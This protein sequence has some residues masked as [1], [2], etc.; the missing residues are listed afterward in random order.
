[1]QTQIFPSLYPILLGLVLLTISCKSKKQ[2]VNNNQ[3]KPQTAEFLQQQLAQQQVKADWL[4]GKMKVSFDNNGQQQK[5]FSTLKMRKDS[6]IWMN[7]KKLGIEGARVQITPDSVYLIDRINGQYS[8][9]G[10]D[11]ITKKFNLPANFSM[12]QN[13]LLGNPVFFTR[14]LT[15]ANDDLNYQLLGETERLTTQYWLNSIAYQLTKMYVVD[16]KDNR[17]LIAQFSDYRSLNEKQQFAYFR[18]IDVDSTEMGKVKVQFEFTEVKLD[19]P[20]TIR[21]SIPDHYERVD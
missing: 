18:D 20:T 17:K 13:F 10:L 9:K 14:D 16:K 8:V 11:F 3:L 2:L 5:A 15:A 12:L 21:F 1:M 4:T 6:V 7:V 19:E